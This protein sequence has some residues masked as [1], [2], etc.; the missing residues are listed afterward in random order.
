MLMTSAW[1]K[2][3]EELLQEMKVDP[4]RG[5]TAQEVESRL[6]QYG[7]NS[8]Q[9]RKKT[10]RWH[11]LFKQFHNPVIYVLVIA[12]AIAFA[13]NEMLDGMAILAIV[14][15]NATIGF[16]Q[17][18]KAEA[19]IEAL[20]AISSPKGRVLREE[21]VIKIDSENIC[22]GDIL[23]LE[24]GDYVVAD[25]R[26][27]HARQL[28]V[29]EAVL[30]GESFS[31]E[32][33]SDTLD[34]EKALGDRTNMLF[35]STAISRGTAKAL[36]IATG[37]KTEIGKIADLME[38]A[39]TNETPLQRRLEGVSRRLLIA[40]ILVIGLVVL[41]GLLNKQNRI[42][43]LMTALSLAVAA[44]PEGLPTVV[45]IAL[46]MAVKRMSRKHAL[47]RKMN[48]VET[49]GTANIICTDKTGTLTTGT[50]KV[51]EA[52][53]KDTD[54]E[55]LIRTMVICNNASLAG[56]GSGDTTEIALLEFAQ[57]QGKDIQHIH[58]TYSRVFEWSFD[59]VRKRMSVAAESDDKIVIYVKG[60]P[61]AILSRCDLSSQESEQVH[62]QVSI[63]SKKGMRV[64]AFANKE[65]IEHD[66]EKASLESI[67]NK[68]NFTG[69]V[70]LADPPRPETIPAIK[71]CQQAGIRIIMI[72]G[73]HPQTAASIGAE[74]GII[75]KGAKTLTGV[76]LDKF[77]DQ[78]LR[79]VVEEVSIYAR[80]SPENKLNLVNALKANKHIVAMTGD[81]VNDAPALKTADIGVAMGKGGTEVARQASSLVLTDDNF[82]TIVDAVEE[83]RAV[84]GNIK[85]TLQYLFSTN[86]A[87]LIFI[88]TTAILGWPI[89]LLPIN[90]L[91]LN[92]VTDGLPSLA[93][94]AEPVHPGFLEHSKRP[95][96]ESFFD[97]I[98][99][100]E[101][102][103]VG[104]LIT[105]ISMGVYYYGLK[106][107]EMNMAR[108]L[109][110]SF[111][112]YTI[113][114]RS[115][116]CRSET[117]TFFEMKPDPKL[118]LAVVGP[119]LFQLGMQH[120]EFLLKLFKVVPL[121]FE[122]SLILIGLS[123]IPVTLV[124][125]YKMWRRK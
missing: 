14:I 67:E 56:G 121:K 9:T 115:F 63:L 34:E 45:T 112:V 101:M 46:V 22:P 113:L 33:S 10:S 106:N 114:F 21:K 84:N 73:D 94:A 3:S 55:L 79:K 118:I 95:S 65:A 38:S 72:T 50:M 62:E 85:R 29:E 36:V 24:A 71:K 58:E 8:I 81:G 123:L 66:F 99:Y 17:E 47:V 104:V 4:E 35:A 87:E 96:S 109:A 26:I 40:G 64:L 37:R 18:S 19:S 7:T 68:L 23:I 125:I 48:A 13:L 74:L 42:D 93:L 92:L 27:I 77:S 120:S 6:M 102:L 103:L 105:I 90:L 31:V 98:F 51:R 76:E 86:L 41:I 91:W 107:Y 49:L 80:V 5:L 16:I 117:L 44:I 122:Y 39:Q 70:A 11:L 108:S 53:P 28:A 1:V 2:T 30:T 69:L 32:K 59:S 110:F 54:H 57:T 88:L 25:A 124:E 83:G 97:R 100:Q 43:I 111:I 89:P 78:E 60:A 75:P 61:E 20:A 52:F 119:V 12:G 15:L 116:S 82:A